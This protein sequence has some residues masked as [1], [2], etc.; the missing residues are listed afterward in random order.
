MEL[1]ELCHHEAAETWAGLD[2]ILV[3]PT[4]PSLH[5]LKFTVCGHNPENLDNYTDEM[6]QLLPRCAEKQILAVEVEFYYLC[7]G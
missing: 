1:D 6:W 7:L 4:P 2:N 3:G 5:T